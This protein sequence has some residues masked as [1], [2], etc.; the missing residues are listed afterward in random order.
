MPIRDGSDP[1]HPLPLF[2]SGHADELEQWASRILKASILVIAVTVSG[3]AIALSLGN[4]V[5]VFANAAASLTDNSAV[6]RGANESTP[7]IQSTAGVQPIQ[8]PAD[9]QAPTPTPG[10]APARDEIAAVPEPANHAQ[11][12]NNEPPSGTLL[13]Q[14]QAWAAKEDARAQKPVEAVQV[15]PA[16]VEEN[17]PAFERLVQKHRKAKSVRNVRAEMRHIRKSKARIH[18]KQNAR[19]QA[20][21]R[22]NTRAQKQPVP[23]TFIPAGFAPIDRVCNGC[24]AS[25]G[26]PISGLAQRS[27][28]RSFDYLV[29]ERLHR[30]RHLDAEGFRGL[31]VNDQLELARPHDGKIGGLF[32][33]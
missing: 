16:E 10:G 12:E 9:V 3:I 5:R 7:T 27:K 32:A 19:G 2:I 24:G 18:R 23:G 13:R 6:Q 4:P 26:Q 17:N 31:H 11:T 28:G 1:H 14:F 20:P 33:L 15:A 29:G 30:V 22:K 21:S 8:S 25:R